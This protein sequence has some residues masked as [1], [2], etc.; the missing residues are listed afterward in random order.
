MVLLTERGYLL[1][2]K[3]LNDDVSWQVQERLVESYF[4]LRAVA[5][6]DEVLVSRAALEQAHRD[7]E[8]AAR[9]TVRIARGLKA[10]VSAHA[11]GLNAWKG[12]G[13][14]A[15]S[16]AMEDPDQVRIPGVAF[17]AVVAD[18]TAAASPAARASRANEDLD[19]PGLLAQLVGQAVAAALPGAVQRA[20]A[21]R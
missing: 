4:R 21:T 8:Q 13:P 3:P 6:G 10:E 19:L 2:V 16:L 15:K 17:H 5:R 9:F 12:L 20:L 7:A 14:T 11:R 1:L 18:L